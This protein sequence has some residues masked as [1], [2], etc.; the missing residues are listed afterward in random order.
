[1]L[2]TNNIACAEQALLSAM[3]CVPGLV[4]DVAAVA[5]S[6]DTPTGALHNRGAMIEAGAHQIEQRGNATLCLPQNNMR[7]KSVLRF[8]P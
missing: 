3:P 4:S 6:P 2:S 5:H 7:F 1:M 8:K